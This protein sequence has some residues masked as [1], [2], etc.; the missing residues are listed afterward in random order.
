MSIQRQ[1][2]HFSFRYIH[3]I[4]DDAKE[5]FKQIV[6]ELENVRFFFKINKMFVCKLICINNDRYVEKELG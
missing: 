5:N 1:D 4:P 3:E 6:T 2:I